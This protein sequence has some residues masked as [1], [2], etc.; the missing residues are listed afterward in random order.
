MKSLRMIFR[1]VLVG[2]LAFMFPACSDCDCERNCNCGSKCDCISI[3]TPEYG[4]PLA[5]ENTPFESDAE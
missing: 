3:N 2:M 5:T 4:V 1:L